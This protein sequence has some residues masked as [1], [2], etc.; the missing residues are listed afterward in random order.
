[1][2][3]QLPKVWSQMFFDDSSTT[4]GKHIPGDILINNEEEIKDIAMDFLRDTNRTDGVLM[5]WGAGVI[6]GRRC[7]IVKDEIKMKRI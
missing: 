4:I 3:E 5:I 2:F 6:Y 1:M 7:S